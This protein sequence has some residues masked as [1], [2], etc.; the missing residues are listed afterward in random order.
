MSLEKYATHD[1]AFEVE[2][3]ESDKELWL[4][5]LPEALDKLK[6]RELELIELSYFE[7][8]SFEEIA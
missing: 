2:L 5:L 3:E 8:K 4:A 1:L 7:E 6:P